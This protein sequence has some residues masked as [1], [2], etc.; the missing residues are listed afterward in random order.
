MAQLHTL[1]CAIF[2]W[3]LGLRGLRRRSVN[4]CLGAGL[5][6]KGET[7]I[8]CPPFDHRVV[9]VDGDLAGEAEIG[10]LNVSQLQVDSFAD[11]LGTG[12]QGNFLQNALA[13]LRPFLPSAMFIVVVAMMMLLRDVPIW[14]RSISSYF[15]QLRRSLNGGKDSWSK[16]LTSTLLPDRPG[17]S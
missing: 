16:L 10:N 2:S 5:R 13:L 15:Y 3:R 14:A 8:L 9:L 7:A 4:T 1:G 6:L 17:P 11:G 12:N